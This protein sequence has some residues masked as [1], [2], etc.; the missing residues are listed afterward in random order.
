M[1]KNETSAA[2]ARAARSV[3]PWL[4]VEPDGSNLTIDSFPTN[5]IVNLANSLRRTITSNYAE[6]FGLTVSEWRFLALLAESSPVNF[7]TLVEVS[8][9][10]KA[11][12]SR[13]MQALQMR[14]F[15]K[16]QKGTTV[17]QKKLP[18]L[19]TRKGQNMYNKILPHACEKQGAL[20]EAL[21]KTEKTHLFTALQKLQTYC[22]QLEQTSKA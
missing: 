16:V 15:A 8:G 4:D 10:D 22:D 13:S 2:P 5:L 21:S 6:Q 7:T 17:N 1:K 3:N 20:L 18:Y 11:L 19:I 14:G 9:S 12:V